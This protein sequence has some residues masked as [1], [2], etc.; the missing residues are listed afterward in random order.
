MLMAILGIDGKKER[1]KHLQYVHCNVEHKNELDV[2]KRN[3]RTTATTN[4]LK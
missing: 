3:L 4:L 2:L 1:E